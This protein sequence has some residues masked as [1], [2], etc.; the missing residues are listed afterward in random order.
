MKCLKLLVLLTWWYSTN[1]TFST[2][3]QAYLQAGV[4][5]M[6][7]MVNFLCLYG[8]YSCWKFIQIDASYSLVYLL[9]YGVFQCNVNSDVVLSLAMH[10]GFSKFISG[11]QGFQ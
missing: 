6:T 9:L 7:L 4:N 10:F 2:K 8:Q 5:G 1:I 11:S 3:K